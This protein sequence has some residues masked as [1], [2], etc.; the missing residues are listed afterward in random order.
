MD[1]K[2]YRNAVN[3]KGELMPI[4]QL[5][6]GSQEWLSYRQ[7]RVMATCTPVILGSNPFKTKL[8]LWEEKQGL[9]FVEMNDAMREGQRKE[10]IARALIEENLGMKFIPVVYESDTHP[11]M[12]AS[13][14]GLSECSKYII[15]IKCPSKPKL[16]NENKELKIPEYYM[17]QML[18]QIM[19]VPNIET[20]YFCT[21]YPEDKESPL[22]IVKVKFN[23][24][25]TGKIIEK[26][27]EF[28]MQMC[29]F[30]APEEWKLKERNR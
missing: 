16:H 12:A 19:C 13:L 20:L 27:Y 18:H 30:E 11:W 2:E 4:I 29:N 9:R 7:N 26:G 5:V 8:E 3:A 23:W 1:S 24:F 14:D 6:Q 15:E 25:L 28:Y 22:C 21:Y 10:P 17:D